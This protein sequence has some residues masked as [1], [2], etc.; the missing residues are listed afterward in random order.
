MQVCA[1]TGKSE[2]LVSHKKMGLL[3]MRKI[4]KF[5]V[6]LFV[7]F[8]LYTYYFTSLAR[9]K[10]ELSDFYGELF[11]MVCICAYMCNYFI[12]KE[13]NDGIAKQWYFIKFCAFNQLFPNS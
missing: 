8:Y 5:F 6:L 11:M 12:G 13:I 3:Y 2:L 4:F 1:D 9:P 7:I 10:L